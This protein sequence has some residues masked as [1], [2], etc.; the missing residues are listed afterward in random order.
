[1]YTSQGVVESILIAPQATELPHPVER[2]WAAAGRGLAGDRYWAATGTYSDARY[3]PLAHVTLVAVEALEEMRRATGV[4]LTP[5]EARRNVL[6]RGID[7]DTLIGVPFRIGGV[8]CYGQRRCEPCR[9][10]ERL[11]RPGVL[12]AL[13]HRGGLR[14]EL[15]GDGWIAV[16]DPVA[17]L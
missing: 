13:V 10:L 2:A 16:G 1:M 11:T 14:A 12:R 6:V 5:A 9:H 15:H 17:A 7:L 4:E 8:R 3:E